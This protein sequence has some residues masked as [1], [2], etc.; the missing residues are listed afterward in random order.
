MDTVEIMDMNLG[1]LYSLKQELDTLL[2]NE[3]SYKSERTDEDWEND[4]VI[5]GHQS[6]LDMVELR[7]HQL[8]AL[9]RPTL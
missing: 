9:P 1:Q 7:I 3:R 4:S 5:A 8:E 2:A 6:R